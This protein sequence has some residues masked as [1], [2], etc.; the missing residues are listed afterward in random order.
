[1]AS[2]FH[3]IIGREEAE[4][5]LYNKPIGSY[6]VRVSE[7]FFGYALSYKSFPNS[8]ITTNSCSPS[9]LFKH[10]LIERIGNGY[11]FFG[12]DQ[13]LHDAL[14]DLINYHQVA[15]ITIGGNEILKESVGQSSFP[16]DYHEFLNGFGV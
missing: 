14:W 7:R 10:F 8:I 5:L 1:M 3:G 2:W 6:L 12:S 16:P 15:P 13:I 11:R 4:R 9:K